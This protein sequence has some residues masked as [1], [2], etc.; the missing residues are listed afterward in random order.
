MVT[1]SALNKTQ[2]ANRM[3]ILILGGLDEKQ[4]DVS[5]CSFKTHS[6]SEVEFIWRI[7][8]KLAIKLCDTE[9]LFIIYFT[10]NAMV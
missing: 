1:I 8:L 2:E 4:K 5:I 3:S 7:T 6:S 9:C 10:V